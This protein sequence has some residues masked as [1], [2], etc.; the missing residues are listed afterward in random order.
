MELIKFA[1]GNEVNFLSIV[2][3]SSLKQTDV[4]DDD[5]WEKD[6]ERKASTEMETYNSL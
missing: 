1:H 5:C 3:I 6:W 4:D 2:V